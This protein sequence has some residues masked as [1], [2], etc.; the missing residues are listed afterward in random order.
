MPAPVRHAR[1]TL[2]SGGMLACL[3]A[4]AI[5]STTSCTRRALEVARP[6]T[7]ADADVDVNGVT[8]AYR[9][10]LPASYDSSRPVPL[11]IML[12]GHGG[13]AATFEESTGMSEKAD[14]E[15]FIVLY[16]QALGSP[17]AWHSAIDGPATRGDIAFVRTLLDTTARRY[18]VDGRRIYVAGH[19]NGGFMTYR[20]ASVLS[21]RVAAI[22]VV[23]GSIGLVTDAGDTIRIATPNAPVA[24]VHLH[25]LADRSVPY[26]GGPESDGPDH[27]IA[28]ENTIGFWTAADSAPPSPPPIPSPTAT[29]CTRATPRVRAR[30]RSSCTPSGAAVTPGSA[31]NRRGGASTPRSRTASTPPT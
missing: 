15:G 19:S 8:R 23:A 6:G 13:H 2:L 21:R 30:R 29:S 12:H 3:L 18:N 7:T 5:A 14:H 16:P 22:G 31:T 26:A 9:I 4:G 24:V 25:G 20:I 28:V 11:V 10:H 27:V 1:R 17:S